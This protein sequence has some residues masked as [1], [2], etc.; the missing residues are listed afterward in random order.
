MRTNLEKILKKLKNN[1]STFE[2]LSQNVY[3]TCIDVEKKEGIIDKYEEEGSLNIECI[4]YSLTSGLPA[5][6][7]VEYSYVDSDGHTE[8]EGPIIEWVKDEKNSIDLSIH[9]SDL[10]E[11][12]VGEEHDIK[13]F[14][15]FI[16]ACLVMP[17][18][19]PGDDIIERD[20]LNGKS[21]CQFY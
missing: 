5:T 18:F 14:A 15:K 16:H 4:I 8:E 10:A 6:I 20:H 21:K 7:S 17:D 19:F 12:L 1:K 9:L 11:F 2:K 13:L 3:W